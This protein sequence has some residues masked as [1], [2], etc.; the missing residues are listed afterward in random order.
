MGPLP[1]PARQSSVDDGCTGAPHID[2]TAQP[3]FVGWTGRPETTPNPPAQ[4]GVVLCF[5]PKRGRCGAP[6]TG[7]LVAPGGGE[8]SELS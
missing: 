4:H 2:S 8:G 3:G 5:M 7:G 1:G 6:R